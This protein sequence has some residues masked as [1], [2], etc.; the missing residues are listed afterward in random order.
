MLKGS[1]VE[2]RPR[3]LRSGTT[4]DPHRLVGVDMR[5]AGGRR[6]RDLVDHLVS[7]FGDANL[8]AVRELAGLRFTLEQCQASV[9]NGD[10]RAREDLVRLLNLIGRREKEL[11]AD[12]QHKRVTPPDLAAYIAEGT[13]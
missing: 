2:G 1:T 7:Q 3:K 11:R 8:E 4:N 5:S 12:Q 6:Y 13:E 9:V 10:A